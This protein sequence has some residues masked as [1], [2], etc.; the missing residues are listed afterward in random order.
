MSDAVPA[1]R[2][3]QLPLMGSAEDPRLIRAATVLGSW[4]DAPVQIL[5]GEP[6]R[7]DDLRTLAAGLGVAVDDVMCFD[8][9]FTAA[10]VAHAQA[11]GPVLLVAAN[12]VAGRAL[13]LA[14]TQP[15]ML[16]AE[17]DDARMPFGPLVVE[18][19]GTPSDLDSLA[20]AAT[21]GRALDQPIRLVSADTDTDTETAT[22]DPLA[23]AEARLRQMGCEVGIDRIR[24]ADEAPPVVAGR[25]RGATALIVAQDGLDRPDVIDRAVELGLNV[26]VAA[27]PPDGAAL[28]EPFGV[29]LDQSVADGP[30]TSE[31]ETMEPAECARLLESHTLARLGYVNAGLPTVVPINYRYHEGDVLFRS[32]AGGKVQAAA[33]NDA[34]CLELDGF[35]E[36]LRSGW[37]VVVHGRLEEIADPSVLRRAWANDPESWVASDQWRWL[38]MVPFQLS[39]RRVIA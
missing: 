2:Q 7:I 30:V 18:Q 24:S 22:G 33:R 6:D 28:P 34:V 11:S 20:L 5:C 23:E 37:S 39:G 21:L 15:V 25:A 14:A 8:E 32:L 4:L 3:V 19:R 26:L 13:A 38:R 35:D 31:L 16:V 36:A 27:V 17:R 29:G 9:P 12:D 1:V 10:A